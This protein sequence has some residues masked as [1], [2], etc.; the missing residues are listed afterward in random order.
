MSIQIS[1]TDTG[2]RQNLW[3]FTLI[4]PVADLRIGI[5]TIREKWKAITGYDP[6]VNKESGE[7]IREIPANFI[8]GDWG[9]IEDMPADLNELEHRILDRPWQMPVFNAWAIRNDYES[10]TRNRESKPIPDTVRTIDR[11]LI[12]IE[13]GATLEHCYINAS[14]GPVYIGRDV[15]VMDGAILRGPLAICEGAVVK[16]GAVIYG[17]TTIGPHC[18]A[19]GEIKNSILMGYTNKSHHGYLGDAVLGEW[20]NLGAGTSCS[21]LKNTGG[22]VRVWNMHRGAFEV[23]GMKCGLLMGDFSRSA[24]HTAFNTG[25][26]TGICANIFGY[27]GLTPKHIPNFAWGTG[28]PGS[29]DIEK[30]LMDINVWMGFKGRE[31]TKELRDALTAL[32]SNT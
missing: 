5:L 26:V 16:S 12:F 25:T 17:G 2:F 9:R 13:E 22:E 10:V 29:Y 23:A 6:Y 20:C 11:G 8:P 32:Y 7:D 1:L 31:L 18:I 19:G 24:I 15:L 14:D 30:A 28:D 21:N 3:P 27:D 4:R